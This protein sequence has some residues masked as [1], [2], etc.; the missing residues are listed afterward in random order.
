MTKEQILKKLADGLI[1]YWHDEE[2]DSSSILQDLIITIL[3][4]E[5]PE[6][7]QKTEKLSDQLFNE[8]D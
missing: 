2:G 4:T 7:L 5:N 1:V 8:N 6:L 3:Q